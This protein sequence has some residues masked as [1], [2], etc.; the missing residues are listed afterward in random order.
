MKKAIKFSRLFRLKQDTLQTFF[1]LTRLPRA[2]KWDKM[3]EMGPL[4][5]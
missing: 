1:T 5:Q 2:G 4:E 3:W